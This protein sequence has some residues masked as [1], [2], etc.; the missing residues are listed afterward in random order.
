MRL[1][2]QKLGNII[3]SALV[4]LSWLALLGGILVGLAQPPNSIGADA[5]LFL[6]ILCVAAVVLW[7]LGGLV[8]LAW[9]WLRRPMRRA[10]PRSVVVVPPQ[11]YL[12][13]PDGTQVDLAAPP[14]WTHPAGGYC[15]RE[16]SPG[17]SPRQ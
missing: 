16:P 3:W 7:L 14:V 10:A 13:D 11:S 5:A 15:A 2:R 12:P 8:V 4:I 1:F 17:G 9:R 6:I